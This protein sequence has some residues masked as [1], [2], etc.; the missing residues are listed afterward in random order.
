[1]PGTYSQLL[2]HIVFSTKGRV[3]WIAAD[4]SERLY[5]YIGGII[6]AEKGVLYDIGGV[7]DHVHIYLQWRPDASVSGLMRTVKARSSKWMHDT[8][9][10]LRG[11]TWQEGYSV[12]SVSK[13][14][15]P[16]VKKYIAGQAEHHQKEDFKSELLRMLRAHGIEFDVKYVFD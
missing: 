13:S 1:M 2:L 8:F 14:Q 5:P 11:L 7:E 15:E 9:P 10:A 6:R 12:F 16:A 3:P 4:V